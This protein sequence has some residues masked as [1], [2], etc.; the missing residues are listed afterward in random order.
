MVREGR[1]FISVAT[2][3]DFGS[4]YY[5]T[6]YEVGAQVTSGSSGTTAAVR[7]GHGF[8][9]NDNFIVGTDAT[10]YNTVTA[11]SAT[12]LTITAMALSAG[13]LLVNLGADTGI[14]APN[15]DGA[16]L[17][18]YTDMDYSNVAANNTVQTDSNGRYRYFH[19][20]VAIWELVRSSTTKPFAVYEAGHSLDFGESIVIDGLIQAGRA[21]ADADRYRF[22]HDIDFSTWASFVTSWWAETIFSGVAA[23]SKYMDGFFFKL[24]TGDAAT[25]GTNLADAIALGGYYEHNS[26][27]NAGN[28]FG[29]ECAS[30][31]A[32]TAT[33]TKL[34][35]ATVLAQTWKGN[36][37]LYS[38]GGTAT[39]AKGL[40]A[41]AKIAAGSGTLTNAWAVEGTVSQAATGTIGSAIAIR[42]VISNSGAGTITNGQNISV[43]SP[44]NSG[45]GTFTN[46]TGLSVGEGSQATNNRSIL[47]FGAVHVAS[48]KYIH[49]NGSDSL[50]DGDASLRGI[51]WNNSTSSVE[52]NANLASTLS[53]T[54]SGGVIGYATGAGGTVTQSTNKSTGVTLSK[55]CGQIT[56]NNASLVA[57]TTV[58]F[59]LTN[60]LI[61]ATDILVLNHVSVGTFGAYTL[62]AR[63]GSGSATIDVRNVT[64]GNLGEAIVI[65]FAIVKG[66]TA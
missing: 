14:T 3:P 52:A 21:S 15:Y 29:T 55:S 36:S 22:D 28:L 1:V 5:V 7:A 60:T 66:V 46:W 13:D 2:D 27:A 61:A 6:A 9:A 41:V 34:V 24:R 16:G 18:I 64:A 23:A 17:T 30:S 56:M 39:T 50:Y 45:G 19:K 26:N 49:L 63:A 40:E 42:S 4:S 25:D 10:K 54:S 8:A 11:V 43:I 65:A 32:G 57:D 38:G 48:G 58:S 35:G 12:T 59:V 20:G 31:L 62:N 44:T 47:S 33:V 51:R 53:I 37:G